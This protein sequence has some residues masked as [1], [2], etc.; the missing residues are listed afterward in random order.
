MLSVEIIVLLYFQVNN[1]ST[2]VNIKRCLRC[3]LPEVYP[4]IY[5]N[6]NSIC[7]Y[8]IYADIYKEREDIIKSELCIKFDRLIKKTK[9]KSRNYDCIVAYSGGKDSTF[10]LYYLKKRYGLNILAHVLDNGF[11]SKIAKENIKRVTKTLQIDCCVTKP[12]T[13]VLT[14]VFSYALEEKIPYP[15]EILALASQVCAVCIGMVLGTTLNK[16]IRLK[17]PLMF[18]GFTPG[19]YPAIS[20][21]NF[22]KVESCMFLSD[23]VYRDDPLDVIK[24]FAD[25]ILEKFGTKIKRYF[26]RSQYIPT[27]LEVPKVLFPFHALLEYSEE[28]IIKTISKIGWIRP[29]DTDSCSTNCLL[30][31]LGNFACIK[32][33]GYHPYIGE[34]AYLVRK[35]LL[36]REEA[37]QA[38]VMDINS[39]AM[40][41]SL[42]KLG[43]K[44]YE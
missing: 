15:K 30:N 25:P 8:C 42:K 44:K 17:V 34:M 29:S 4:G 10:L 18:T 40:R 1:M 41:F 24:I 33:Q 31:T 36:S 7:N 43:F 5:F 23:R 3:G 38:E 2:K 27:G 14:S 12:P 9:G 35:G 26:F 19:Q 32:Q 11:I 28:N 6:A 22:F 16:A 39:K 21:E 13:E 37:L 20:L